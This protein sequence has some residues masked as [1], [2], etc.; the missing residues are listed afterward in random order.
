MK[1]FIVQI[2]AH[3]KRQNVLKVHFF[4]DTMRCRDELVFLTLRK[5]VC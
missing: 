3:Q 5:G 2:G 4:Y 1:T